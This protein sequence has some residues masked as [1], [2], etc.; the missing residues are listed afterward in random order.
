VNSAAWVT[1]GCAIPRRSRKVN[2]S[3]GV[4]GII[5]RRPGSERTVN[6]S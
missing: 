2:R 3:E 1:V 6:A 5:Q 4:A